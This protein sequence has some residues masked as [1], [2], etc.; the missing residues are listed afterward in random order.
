MHFNGI[1][2]AS[3]PVTR[4]PNSTS[5]A[6]RMASLESDQLG[7]MD[8]PSTLTHHYKLTALQTCWDLTGVF[9]QGF[10]ILEF[11]NHHK[12]VDYQARMNTGN[13]GEA[14]IPHR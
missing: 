9:T 12:T 3:V 14:N 11:L 13:D 2:K 8:I 6:L 7:Y 5:L 10:T 1:D 4:T